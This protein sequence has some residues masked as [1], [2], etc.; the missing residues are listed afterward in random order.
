MP[1]TFGNGKIC[2]LEIPAID[3]RRSAAFYHAVVGWQIRER[4]DRCLAFDDG[5]GQVSGT[6]VVGRPPS[7]QPGLLVYIMVDDVA[8]TLDLVRANGGKVVQPIGGDAPE[9]TA[10]F[11]DPAG[12]VLGLYQERQ[13]AA[14]N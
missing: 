8:A 1:P 13:A 11:R 5:V 12:N 4:G 9:I 2:Y 7:S 6:W 10:R 3:V 14:G